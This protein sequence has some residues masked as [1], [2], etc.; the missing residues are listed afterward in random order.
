G[1]AAPLQV[2][3]ERGGEIE[4]R[5][6]AQDE[7]ERRLLLPRPVQGELHVV[8]GG[9]AQLLA[10]VAQREVGQVEGALPGQRE[11][12][13]QRGVRGQ[14]VQNEPVRGQRVHRSLS[15]VQRLGVLRRR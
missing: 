4:R 8:A 10:E 13:G 14:S 2:R 7:R 9:V 5:P 1:G 6:C 15:V 3:V 12:G 11:V